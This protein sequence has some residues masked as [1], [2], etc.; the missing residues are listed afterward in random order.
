MKKKL[1]KILI[2]SGVSLGFLL[3]IL[4]IFLLVFYFNSALTKN[5]LE[6]SIARKTGAKIRIARLS[7]DLF[8]LKVKAD[9]VKYS[10]KIGGMEIDVSLSS[11]DVESEIKRALKRQKPFLQS[12]EVIGA[13]MRIT[14][15]EIDEE[16]EIDF[17]KY[18]LQFE[19]LMSYLDKIDLK[20]FNLRYTLLSDS[21]FLEGCSLSLSRSDKEGEYGYA[22]STEK[23]ELQGKSKNIYLGSSFRTAG[24]ISLISLPHLES[25]LLFAPSTLVLNDQEFL[26][27]EVSLKLDGKFQLD[28]KIFS[29]SQLEM[30]I[31]DIFDISGSFKV[32]S[33]EGLSVVSKT[34]VQIKDLKKTSELVDPFLGSYLPPQFQDFALEGS[35]NLEGDYRFRSGSSGEREEMEAD[36]QL[37]TSKVKVSNARFSFQ[38][39]IFSKFRLKGRFPDLEFSGRLEIKDGS[40]AHQNLKIQDFSLALSLDGRSSSLNKAQFSGYF[41]ALSFLSADTGI[42]FDQLGFE[43]LGSLNFIEKNI[44]L[45]GL[46]LQI[47]HLSPIQIDSKMDLRSQGKKYFHLAI[48][49]MDSADLMDLFS[50][51]VP[52][53]ISDLEP[54]GHISLDL[55]ATQSPDYEDGWKVSGIMNFSDWSF[56]NPSFTVA[57][58]SLHPELALQGIFH[59]LKRQVEFSGRLK[60]S[61]GEALWNEYYVDWSLYPLQLN[62]SGLFDLPSQNLDGLSLEALFSTLGKLEAKGLVRIQEPILMNLDIRAS[63]LD[64]GSI[65]SFV[66]QQQPE[67]T[68]IELNGEA[69]S[70][71]R[72][73]QE[74]DALSLDG[75][76]QLMN[77][78]LKS[79]DGNLHLE[80]IEMEIPFIYENPLQDS[81]DKK[82]PSLEKGF[83]RIK[84]F[85]T[86][87]LSA[88]PLHISINAGRNRF[89]MEPLDVELFGGKVAL[90]ESMFTIGSNPDDIKGQLSLSLIDVDISKFPIQSEKFS[91]EGIVQADPYRIDMTPEM[92]STEGIIEVGMFGTRI[93]VENFKISNPF[94]QDRTISCDIHFD[95][96]DLERLTDAIPFG[97]VTGIL[98][99]EIKD[100]AFSYGQPE[101]FIM[102]LESVKRKGVPQKFSLGAVNDLSILSSGQGSSVSPKKGFTRFISEFGYAKIGISC[103]LKNDIF[104]LRGTIRE[105]GIEYLVKRSWLFGISVVNKMPRSRIRFKDMMNRLKRIGQSEGPSTSIQK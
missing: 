60:L 72:L 22:L 99:G 39:S 102:L 24:K 51:F 15:K 66:S 61:K 52:K 56:H 34:R 38:N 95:D 89:V 71:I 46:K 77:A 27:P 55:E 74:E 78:S 98:R 12:V 6:K 37:R 19:Q 31:S 42:E 47:N 79:R 13:D 59:P 36:F 104:T 18:M 96:M 5:I 32:E 57:G 103:S 54:E 33:R 67:D 69:E 83:L 84:E 90:R 2:I 58:E 49:E 1:K 23:V 87:F 94:S 25:E 73:R 44:D 105:D 82:N 29:L 70:Q 30:S 4:L 86:P 43:G 100:L 10:Q 28:K 92:L 75:Y 26:V 63:E 11:L 62:L 21:I 14:I 97:R 76:L 93:I 88:S 50:S 45:V 68:S 20:D 16:M 101:S 8:P 17:Q 3:L 65:Y 64:L 80:G 53:E 41:K 91:L 35:V 48:T 40:L 7:Y 85:K 81:I 9:S